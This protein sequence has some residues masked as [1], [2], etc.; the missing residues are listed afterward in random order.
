MSHIK[1]W[2]NDLKV[3]AANPLLNLELDKFQPIKLEVV[4]VQLTIL[5]V[6]QKLAYLTEISGW[7]QETSQVHTLNQQKFES[8]SIVLNG[9]WVKGD[10][11]YLLEFMG[12][13]QWQLQQYKIQACSAEEATHL[14]EKIIQREIGI[15]NTRSLVYQRLW[16]PIDLEKNDTSPVARVAIFI[17]FEELK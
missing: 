5:Q 3:I 17:G 11:S 16:Q 4:S 9:E 6:K 12:R 2:L 14:S 7:I 8:Q 13:D 1:Q 15:K 10:V